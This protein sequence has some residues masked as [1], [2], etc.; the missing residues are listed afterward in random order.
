LNAKKVQTFAVR[1]CL[2]VA[3]LVYVLVPLL[4]V[5]CSLQ[6]STHHHL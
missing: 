2:T 4:N 3:L 5:T 1:S 6:Q